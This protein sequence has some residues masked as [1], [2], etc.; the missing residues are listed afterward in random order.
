MIVMTET[1]QKYRYHVTGSRVMTI[2]AGVLLALLGVLFFI[3][4]LNTMLF[5]DI[6]IIIGL[7]VY[8]VYLIISFVGTPSGYRDGWQLAMGIVLVVCAIMILASNAANII[9]SFAVMLGIV[10]MMVGINQIIGSA[11]LKGTPGAG[12]I[13]FSGIINVLLALFLI[14]AP[15]GATAAIGIIEGVY[16]C[17]AGVALIIEGFAKR[18]LPSI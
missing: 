1:A 5:T 7:L 6:F 12:F 2:I 16:L 17:F 3:F 13:L 4:P 8:G 14:V 18:Q 10:A 9:V 11:Y 15:F